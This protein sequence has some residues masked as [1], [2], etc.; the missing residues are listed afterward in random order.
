MCGPRAKRGKGHGG[1]AQTQGSFFEVAELLSK[2]V[3]LSL[4]TSKWVAECSRAECAQRV[5]AEIST[6]TPNAD[7]RG[8]WRCWGG[9]GPCRG[10]YIPPRF[11]VK[12][13]TLKSVCEAGPIQGTRNDSRYFKPRG[14]RSYHTRKAGRGK[15]KRGPGDGTRS[16]P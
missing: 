13:L 16:G 9:P 4:L 1:R 2:Q 11:A 8:K 10:A 6:D 3:T 14:D 15:E 12:P 5:R 7:H